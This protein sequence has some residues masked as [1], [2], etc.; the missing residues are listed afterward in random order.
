MFSDLMN[1]FANNVCVCVCDNDTIIYNVSYVLLN[2]D[3]EKLT[4]V[5]II[6]KE[7]NEKKNNNATNQIVNTE[8]SGYWVMYIYI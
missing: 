2:N 3:N 4:I 1:N 6:S 7:R 8:M 5:V